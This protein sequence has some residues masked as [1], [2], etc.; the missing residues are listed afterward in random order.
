MSIEKILLKHG[1]NLIKDKAIDTANKATA[2]M[3]YG[4]NK[5]VGNIVNNIKNMPQD[6]YNEA[7]RNF[8]VESTRSTFQSNP[9]QSTYDYFESYYSNQNKR[10]SPTPTPNLAQQLRQHEVNLNKHRMSQFKF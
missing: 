2:S 3:Q 10:Y 9:N 5:E 7:M 8:N 1:V 4:L 6:F